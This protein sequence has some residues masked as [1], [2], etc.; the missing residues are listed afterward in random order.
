MTCRKRLGY[1]HSAVL[2]DTVVPSRCHHTIIRCPQDGIARVSRSRLAFVRLSN[3]FLFRIVF[4]R[5][6]MPDGTDDYANKVLRKH[7]LTRCPNDGLPKGILNI[8]IKHDLD[9]SQCLRVIFLACQR[10]C[11]RSRSCCRCLKKSTGNHT[12]A[13]DALTDVP[14]FPRS[15]PNFNTSFIVFPSGVSFWTV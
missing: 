13:Q 7:D 5:R 11:H 3:N 8:R 1:S 15:E 4:V 6:K 12:M 10:F 14:T 2:V 9:P